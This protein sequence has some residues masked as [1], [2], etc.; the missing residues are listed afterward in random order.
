MMIIGIIYPL[1]CH[2]AWSEHGWLK[3]TAFHDFSGSGTVHM[4]GGAACILASAIIGPR[5]DVFHPLTGR[6]RTI[7]G[8][9]TPVNRIFQ[10][11]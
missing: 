5:T 2:W 4:V 1:C 10:I 9:S 11:A 6:K 3:N 8:H 7:R